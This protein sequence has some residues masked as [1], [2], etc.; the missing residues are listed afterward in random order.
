MLRYAI[1]TVDLRGARIV[2]LETPARFSAVRHWSLLAVS[3]HLSV[4]RQCGEIGLR[5]GRMDPTKFLCSVAGVTPGDA[6]I[7]LAALARLN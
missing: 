4:C 7:D 2:M 3:Q 1:P 6:T 5:E